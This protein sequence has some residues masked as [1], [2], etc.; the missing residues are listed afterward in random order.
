MKDLI[1]YPGF[2]FS[3]TTWVKF[4]LLYINK[5]NPIIPTTGE[6]YLSDSFKQILDETDLIHFHRP[7]FDEGMKLH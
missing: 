2:E 3:D 4:A 5:L 7:T 1:F 6:S